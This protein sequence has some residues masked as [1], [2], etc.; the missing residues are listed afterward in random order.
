[1]LDAAP[2]ALAA[3]DR[4]WRLV[5]AN[6]DYRRR[7]GISDEDIGQT[8]WD[9]LPVLIGSHSEPHLRA[10]MRDDEEHE[11]VV[12]GVG[13][14]YRVHICPREE[15]LLVSLVDV[16]EHRRAELRAARLADAQ[17][18]LR[19]VAEAAVRSAPTAELLATI[20]RELG[21]LLAVCVTA[22]ARDRD[23][24]HAELLGIWTSDCDL[25]L[26]PGVYRADPRHG[27]RR[28]ILEGRPV[29]CSAA[30]GTLGPIF[31][32]AGCQASLAVP[33]DAGGQRWGALVTA[34]MNPGA[35]LG[36][37]AERQRELSELAG[38]A[39]GNLEGHAQLLREAT[40]D[41]LTGL[42][43]H[44]AFHDR[45]RVEIERARRAGRPLSLAIL[46]VDD[47]RLLN[48]VRGHH[49]GERLLSTVALTL[50]EF[51]AGEGDV[52]AR[53]GG[54][55]FALLLHGVDAVGTMAIVER[56]RAALV[57]AVADSEGVSITASAGIC[58]L[59]RAGGVER[60]VERAGSALCWSKAHGR[61]RSCIFD[62]AV[63]R[64]P[65]A[66]ERALH[67]ERSSALV[68]ITALARAIDAKHPATRRHSERVAALCTRLATVA[69]WSP[70]AIG[71][72][73]QAALVHDVG[74]IGIPDAILL[75]PGALDDEEMAQMQRHALL[76]AEMLDGVLSA[77]QVG[78]VRG[79]HERP[80]GAG[81]PDGLIAEQIDDG[82]ALLALADAFEAIVTRRVYSPASSVAD[83]VERCVELTGRQFKPI[84]TDALCALLATGA[85]DAWS[86][87]SA[88]QESA[89]PL[90]EAPIAA[91]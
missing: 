30:D 86:R 75:K 51:A 55:E 84:A 28:A 81:Y 37:D 58:D 56:A 82:A 3:I 29:R 90:P 36:D 5:Y 74:K 62:P 12:D 17:T 26:A 35:F 59:D 8:I 4:D 53:L 22:V 48:E 78:W 45:A 66:A 52:L 83:A 71:A 16:T 1:M 68:G 73:H 85:V 46:D 57:S 47:F 60:L 21:Q 80:D 38:V 20:A 65:S 7:F 79:H 27:F 64:Q 18:M 33:I 10:V 25:E 67:P 63:V 49:A 13:G 89:T 76:G 44:R 6:G 77:Q 14:W 41:P 42:A 19:R 91:R 15:G 50:G 39:I 23:G 70:E 54:D 11:Y 9:R 2:V 72:L 69:G 88:L 34:S 31:A 24:T 32:R 87:A 43:N 40:T 61:T